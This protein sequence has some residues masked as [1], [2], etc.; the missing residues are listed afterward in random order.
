MIL[1]LEAIHGQVV[2]G[3]EI[4]LGWAVREDP[5][6][7]MLDM[8]FINFPMLR[9]RQYQMKYKYQHTTNACTCNVTVG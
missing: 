7:W 3:V 8:T 1:M 2:L 9:K 6:D 4:L 5:I